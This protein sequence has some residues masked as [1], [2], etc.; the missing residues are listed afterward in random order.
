M[1]SGLSQVAVVFG[2][3]VFAVVGLFFLRLLWLIVPQDR[4]KWLKVPPASH[5]LRAQPDICP[6]CGGIYMDCPCPTIG[7]WDPRFEYKEIN[8]EVFARRIAPD[9]E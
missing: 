4:T 9:P 2:T 8:G 1:I 5:T 6:M 7:I 3:G